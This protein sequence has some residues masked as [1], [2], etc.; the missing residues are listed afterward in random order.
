MSLSR[1]RQLAGFDFDVV[2]TLLSRGWTGLAGVISVILIPIFLTATQQGY[3]YTFLSLLGLQLLFELGLGQVTSQ[4]VAHEAASLQGVADGRLVGEARAIDRLASL[5]R[6][7]RRWYGVVA[8]LFMLIGGGIGGGFL[9]GRTQLPLAEWMPVWVVLVVTT[10]VNLTYIPVLAFQEGLGRVG[11]VARFR[12][13]QSVIGNLAFWF[14]LASGFSLWAACVAPLVYAVAAR[15]WTFRSAPV[16]YW[17]KSLPVNPSNAINWRA[18]VLPF[19]WRI[20]ISAASGYFIFY[21]LTPFVFASDGAVEAG[22]FGVAMT[23]FTGISTLG[24]SWVYAKT[25]RLAMHI[26]RGEWL[27]LNRL[28][29]GAM[30][31]SIGFTALASFGVVLIVAMLG[32][33]EL[34]QA[35]RISGPSVLICLAAVCIANTAV[36]SMASYMRAHRREPMLAVS[37]VGALVTGLAAYLGSRHGVFAMSLLYSMV[38]ICV[39]LPWTICLF[40][41]YFRHSP[42]PP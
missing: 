13:V 3:Y 27:E 33:Y 15:I 11:D 32:Y 22:K 16:H 35:T 5:T 29:L 23:L 18:D 30:W 6:S 36:S 20:A 39:L 10:A 31:R 21:A 8:V 38:A 41:P 9:F 19:Q 24:A 14:A 25:P 2:A 34:P 42:P 7:L 28:F 26:A 12:L 4:V 17:L 37:V 1:I 40:M